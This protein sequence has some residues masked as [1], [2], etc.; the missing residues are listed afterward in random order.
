M[1]PHIFKSRTYLP[2][3]FIAQSLK[4]LTLWYGIEKVFMQ[5]I[6]L[7]AIDVGLIT[8]GLCLVLLTLNIPTGLLADRWSRKYMLLAATLVVALSSIV[9]GSSHS[10]ESY[11]V[12][13]MGNALSLVM[14]SG[15]LPALVYDLLAEQGQ[16]HRFNRVQG[17]LSATYQVSAFFGALG[18]VAVTACLPLADAY[19][20]SLIPCL[21]SAMAIATVREPHRY[22]PQATKTNSQRLRR[23]FRALKQTP[24]LRVLG[25][26]VV[27]A[28][29]LECL[30][31]DFGQLYYLKLGLGVGAVGVLSG[32]AALSAALGSSLSYRLG[33]K[34]MYL[35]PL[36]LLLWG[37]ASFIPSVWTLPGFLG[38]II[39]LWTLINETTTLIQ[40]QLS[41]DLRATA[42]S[43]LSTITELGLLIITP[44]FGLLAQHHSVAVSFQL[45]WNVGVALL[46][47]LLVLGYGRVKH[48]SQNRQLSK[49]GT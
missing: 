7:D 29:I 36:I 28:S 35:Y 9:L 30:L 42:S 8:T 46:L 39:M 2:Q 31:N 3:L 43:A 6:G 47:V 15:T 37:I 41:S 16:Q 34:A 17:G 49:V 4:G 33:P 25:L 5:S 14:F 44:V 24:S 20:I 13:S 10:F 11:F 22:Q 45:T 19:Y 27:S 1:V 40:H 21:L 23:T 38:C 32:L 26:L 18:G 48:V 12:G